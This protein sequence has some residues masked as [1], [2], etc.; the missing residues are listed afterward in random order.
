MRPFLLL[1]FLL[2]LSLQ[3]QGTFTEVAA[4]AGIVHKGFC[5]SQMTGGVAWFDYDAD[6]DQDLYTTGGL[7]VN[8]L[9]RNNGDG[10]FSDVTA[11]AGLSLPPGTHTQGV[12]TGDIDNDG[13]RELYVSTWFTQRNYFFKNNGD[14]TFSD[15]SQSSGV[16]LDTLWTSAAAFE[17]F[18]GDGFL[19]LYTVNYVYAPIVLFDSLGNQV[20]YAHRCDANS[21]FL[22]NQDGTFTDMANAYAVADTG[23]GLAVVLSDF[24]SDADRDILIA[25][26]F[27]EWVSPNVMYRNQWPQPFVDISQSSGMDLQM[28]GMGIAAGDYDHDLD[29]DYYITDIG[30]ASLLRNNGDGTFSDLAIAAGVANDSLLGQARTS[31][32]AIFLDYDHDTWLDLAVSN[33]Y[34][35]LLPYLNNTPQDPNA[36]YRNLGNGTFADVSLASG[37][38]DTNAARGMAAADYDQDGDLDLFINVVRIDTNAPEFS[39]LYRNDQNSGNHWLQVQLQGLYQN[40][41]AFGSRVEIVAGGLHQVQEILSGSSHMSQNAS[42]AHFGLGSAALVDSILVTWPNGSQQLWTGISADTALRLVEDTT[43]ILGRAQPRFRPLLLRAYPQP[44]DASV[45]LEAV[46]RAPG[47]VRWEVRDLQGRLVRV[48]QAASPTAVAQR[49]EWDGHDAKGLPLPAGSYVITARHPLGSGSLRIQKI[50]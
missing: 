24:D 37:I 47:T 8:S 23:C 35:Q 38:A 5:N 26:D 28:Y 11:V 1:L 45:T 6:G 39:L 2:P 36:L 48:L 14:G 17:D 44:F 18:N 20:A 15:I 42:T 49:L 33:G 4:Q 9:Y 50:R 25:N 7:L 27:G 34:I 29:P 12:L 40:R 22:N 43:A 41:D 3:G 21:L 31:W 32:G 10:T 19:D 30:A 16:C 46:T 13:Y